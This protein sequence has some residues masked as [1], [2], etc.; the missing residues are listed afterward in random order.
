MSDFQEP[1]PEWLTRTGI[2]EVAMLP[3]LARLPI[4][5]P[6]KRNASFLEIHHVPNRLCNGHVPQ[7]R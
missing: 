5:K 2:L 1:N 6:A 3:M 7:T 4:Y